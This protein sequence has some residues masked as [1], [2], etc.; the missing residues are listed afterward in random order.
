MHLM[1]NEETRRLKK[2]LHIK[3]YI[4]DQ[5]RPNL[6]YWKNRPY[7]H[8]YMYRGAFIIIVIA[9]DKRN[10]PL[11]CSWYLQSSW[12]RPTQTWKNKKA[13][14]QHKCHQI[15]SISD[16]FK[17]RMKVSFYKVTD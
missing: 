2:H 15:H 10:K 4:I 13:N 6:T 8:F 14:Q 3:V 1:S 5:C 17:N 16:K 9:L 7:K 12:R 11:G